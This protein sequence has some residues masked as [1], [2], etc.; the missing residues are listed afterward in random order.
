M[1]LYLCLGDLSTAEILGFSDVL[2]TKK[3][4]GVPSQQSSPQTTLQHIPG[5]GNKASLLEQLKQ[6]MPWN[7]QHQSPQQQQA[8]ASYSYQLLNQFKLY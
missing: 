2:C 3:Q 6:R 7:Q 5:V 4:Q 8:S 1:S